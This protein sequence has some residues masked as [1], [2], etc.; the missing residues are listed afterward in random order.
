M[1]LDKGNFLSPEGKCFSFDERANGYARGEGVL[2]LVLKSLPDALRDGDIV[3]AV[4]RGSGTN[5]DG[6]T[7]TLTQPSTVLQE[8]LIRRVY[9]QAGLGF[10]DTRFFEAH[11]QSTALLSL[12]LHL[13][14]LGSR[15]LT[16]LYRHWY[17][18]GGSH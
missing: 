17:R 13:L 10:E 8:A 6:R 11:G 1:L 3:R 15:I 12:C 4:V 16:I 5:Q 14:M 9:K 2:A 7:P 18:G